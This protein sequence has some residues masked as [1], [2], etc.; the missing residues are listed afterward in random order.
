M[1]GRSSPD[2][3]PRVTGF[4]RLDGT[5]VVRRRAAAGDRRRGRHAALRLQRGDHREPL[6]RDRRRPS[7]RLPARHALRAEGQLD[8]GHRPAAARPRQRAPTP[9]RGGKSRSRGAPASP[10]RNRLHR[11]R[12]VARRAGTGD[13]PRRQARST[14]N[15]P[16]SSS[17]IEAIAAARGARAR[18]ALRVNPDIDAK[19]HPHISTGLKINKF[20]VPLD[21]ARGHRSRG[22]AAVPGWSWS[23]VH[24]PRRLADHR[25]RR[26]CAAPPTRWSPWP[27]ELRDDAHRPR[28]PRSRRRPRHLLRRQRPVPTA[29][30]YAAALVPDASSDRACRSCSNRAAAIVGPAGALLSPGDRRQ[31][32]H[33]AARE[34]VV[35]DAGMTELMRPALYNAFHRIEPVAGRRR[36]PRSS[37]DVVGPV[38]ESSDASGATAAAAA[39]R[40]AIWSRSSTPAPTAR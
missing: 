17:A 2:T 39:R 4:H 35:L 18:V 16:A 10:R 12:Q 37:R 36:R 27:R 23:A 25:P 8:P 28:A 3:L 38:C 11:R 15:R 7:P 26:R 14:P 5:L 40:S 31:G 13:R 32:A 6:P 24:V 1:S 30:D 29:A 22:A 20:G 19:S 33:R 34:F 21:E 9:T